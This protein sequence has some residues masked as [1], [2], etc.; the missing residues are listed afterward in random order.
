MTLNALV[1]LSN[2]PFPNFPKLAANATAAEVARALL[3]EPF[4]AYWEGPD[5]KT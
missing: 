5:L 3:Q 1:Q 2:A 4:R